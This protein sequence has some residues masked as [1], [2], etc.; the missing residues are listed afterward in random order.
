MVVIVR[1][2]IVS[3]V[4]EVPEDSVICGKCRGAGMLSKYDQGVKSFD[5]SPELAAKVECR[6]CEG[7]GYVPK[8]I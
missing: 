1:Y 7:K 8:V 4:V 2:K 5:H 3:E 6:N